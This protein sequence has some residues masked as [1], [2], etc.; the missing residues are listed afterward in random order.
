MKKMLLIAAF[1][2]LTATAANAQWNMKYQGDIEAGYSVGVGTFAGDRINIRTTHG[3]RFNDYLF[4]GLGTGLDIYTGGKADFTLPIYAAV[5]G[6][7]PVADRL[8][9]VGGLDAGGS[10]GLSHNL[11]G[12]LIVPQVGVA[13]KIT[14]ANALTFTVGYNAQKWSEKVSGVRVSVNSDAIM[15][16]IGYQF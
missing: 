6:Y 10:I 2:A 9:L 13:Y 3:I 4:A 1:A 7:L 5:K 15:F 16:K 14:D 11:N 8:D 12:M